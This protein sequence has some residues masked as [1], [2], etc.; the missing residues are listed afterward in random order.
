[1]NDYL[2]SFMFYA[3][4]ANIIA[5]PLIFFSRRKVHWHIFEYLFIYFPWFAFIALTLVIFGGLD[6][7]PEFS[8]IKI[9]LL[10]FQSIGSGIMG[11]IDTVTK[12][13][14]QKSETPSRYHYSHQHIYCDIA[15][16]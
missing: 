4:P 14:N 12:T 1:M 10:V 11:G 13:G 3:I 6:Q 2:V 7:V 5:L 16:C 9:F 8:A 15:L